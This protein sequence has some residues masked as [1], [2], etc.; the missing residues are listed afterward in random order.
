M[1]QGEGR[2]WR[3]SDH[4]WEPSH[5]T[6]HSFRPNKSSQNQISRVTCPPGPQ[7]G[8]LM[9]F[10][11]TRQLPS[12]SIE[13][14]NNQS[15]KKFTWQ[16]Y[17]FLSNASYKKTPSQLQVPI[18]PY[19]SS[20]PCCDRPPGRKFVWQRLICSYPPSKCLAPHEVLG[21]CSKFQVD[22]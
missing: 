22:L 15:F 14:Q 6:K 2:H 8:T 13:I 18:H 9:T 5:I 1:L 21:P 19:S 10:P 17:P 4:S 7:Q 11:S 3:V 20:P 16:S 12:I